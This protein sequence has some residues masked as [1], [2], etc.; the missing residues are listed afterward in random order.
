MD[1]DHIFADILLNHEFLVEDATEKYYTDNTV[2][3]PS[4][5]EETQLMMGREQTLTYFHVKDFRNLIHGHGLQRSM[6]GI[7]Q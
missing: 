2:G 1:A 4:A 5:S 7:Y 3:A 6:Y